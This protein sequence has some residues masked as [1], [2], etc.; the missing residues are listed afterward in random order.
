MSR[1]KTGAL[2]PSI[3]VPF[4]GHPQSIRVAVETRVHAGCTLSHA[5]RIIQAYNMHM[6]YMIIYAYFDGICTFSDLTNTEDKADAFVSL[7]PKTA[8]YS[9]WFAYIRP[10]SSTQ[11]SVGKQPPHKMK[12]GSIEAGSVC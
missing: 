3:P 5:Y 4:R 12:N 1:S 6:A 7:S 11:N 2:P 10:L 8:W 9:V